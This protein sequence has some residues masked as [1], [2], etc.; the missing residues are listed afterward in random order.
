MSD[1]SDQAPRGLSLKRMILRVALLFLVVLLFPFPIAGTWDWPRR[2]QGG[3]SG[4]HRRPK[5]EE[6]GARGNGV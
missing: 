5:A 3:G 4:A 1:G 6:R 2:I